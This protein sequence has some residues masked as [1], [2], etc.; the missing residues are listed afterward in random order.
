[1]PQKN[2]II[3][4][5][6]SF[7]ILMV[8][9][10]LRHVLFPPIPAPPPPPPPLEL[11]HKP[12]WASLPVEF[13]VIAPAGVPGIGPALPQ[14]TQLALADWSAGNREAWFS[15][16]LANKDKPVE[17]PP[18]PAPAVAEKP[19]KPDGQKPPKNYVLGDSDEFNIQ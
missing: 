9:V 5:L 14:V 19:K 12:L 1:M 13:M 4:C 17:K 8:W 16:W 11:P 15:A 18:K 7:L 3:F 10:P 6:I 2:L